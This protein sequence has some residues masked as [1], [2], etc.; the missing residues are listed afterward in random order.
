MLR[1]LLLD[2]GKGHSINQS[3]AGWLAVLD[4]LEIAWILL[5]LI[6]ERRIPLRLFL[7]AANPE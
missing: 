5:G 2:Y 3:A 4:I 7:D 6:L 1:H